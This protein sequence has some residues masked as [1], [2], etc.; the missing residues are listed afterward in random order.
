[1][2]FQNNMANT[3]G[4]MNARSNFIAY[5]EMFGNYVD[6]NDSAIVGTI[7]RMLAQRLG[8]SDPP[9]KTGALVA[10][11]QQDTMLELP[12]VGPPP[13]WGGD[14]PFKQ[15]PL[16]TPPMRPP[17]MG[18]QNT[19]VTYMPD[20]AKAS[21]ALPLPGPP[22][23]WGN[24][25]PWRPHHQAQTV[26]GCESGKGHDTGK[27]GKPGKGDESGKGHDAGKGGKPGKRRRKWK[28]LR[29]RKGWQT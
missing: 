3:L 29:P 9:P 5:M 21:A 23:I 8:C 27:S 4:S 6:P 17:P 12:P 10:S 16:T 18:F 2:N 13:Y 7:P 24:P 11:N 14:L 19:G 26:K 1:M 28:R 22:P 15:P 20:Q 25:G